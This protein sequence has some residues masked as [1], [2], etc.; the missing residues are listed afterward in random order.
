MADNTHL[1]KVLI[2]TYYWP[3]AGGSGVQRVLKFAKY[4]PE[5]GWEPVILTV[6][7]GEYPALDSSFEDDI[8]KNM[9]VYKTKSLE[10]FHI[11]KALT[12]QSRDTKID[13]NILKSESEGIREKISK[14]IRLNIF[15][16]DA[17]IGWM[18]YAIKQG[19]EI[20]ENE[21]ISVIFSTSPPH[22][23]QLSAM[24]IAQKSKKPW[25]ADF[26]D[27]WTSIAYYQKQNR[28][29]LTKKLD[30]YLEKKVLQACKKPITVSYSIKKE[31]DR[32]GNRQD[33]EVI[34]NG[35]DSADFKHHNYI[36]TPGK[37]K[38]TYAGFISDNSIP[39]VLLKMISSNT[40]SKYDNIELHIY[41]K[42]TDSFDKAVVLYGVES[43]VIKHGYVSHKYLAEQLIQSDALLMVVDDV[44]DNKGILT[45]KLFDYMGSKR[46]IIA[47]GPKDGEVEKIIHDTSSGWYVEYGDDDKMSQCLEELIS[48]SFGFEF[49]TNEFDRRNLTRKLADVLNEVTNH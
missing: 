35:Y 4:L 43:K 29:T 2:I 26:R 6:E 33:T 31:L 24:R 47:I 11:Y 17:R 13:T 42:T 10:P 30:R 36:P 18:A 25:V 5:F 28:F 7:N 40:T 34:C 38:I 32:T 48:G 27:P 3:P 20:I 14:W 39:D 8:P 22:S 23:L 49:D 45:G 37:I 44:P 19:I 16:P 12:G 9:K 41:G 21:N 15:I 1:K 46:P